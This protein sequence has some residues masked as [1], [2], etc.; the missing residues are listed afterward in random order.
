MLGKWKSS[1]SFVDRF[2]RSKET[3]LENRFTSLRRTVADAQDFYDL[4]PCGYHSVNQDGTVVA[5]NDTELRW[6]GYTRDEVVGRMRFADLITREGRATFEDKFREFKE[7]GGTTNLEFEIV[8]KDSTTFPV[9]LSAT[10]VRDDAGNY[11]SVHSILLDI[12]ER[13]RTEQA[14]RETNEHLRL[15]VHNA[16]DYALI[17]LDP[18]GLV[19]SWNPGA[20]RI[21][22]YCPEEIIGKHFSCFYPAEV[23][24]QG[25]P[26]VELE[27]AAAAGRFEDEGW[28]VRKDG[29]RFWANVIITALRDEAGRLRG[30]S[31]LT[32]D[33]T[34]RRRAEESIRQLNAE[35]EQ[36]VAARTAELA[37]ANRDLT[38]KNQ[39]N[40][41][42]VYSVSHDLRAPLVNLQGFSRELEVSCR[43][44]RRLLDADSVPAPVRKRGLALLDEDMAE[45]LRFIQTGVLRLGRIIDALLHLSRVGRVE[46]QWQEVDIADMTARVIASLR[47]TIDERGATVTA[48]PL[49]PARGDATALEQVFANLIG[50]ALKYLDPRRPG[51]IEV[52]AARPGP[53]GL[54]TYYVRDNG[55]GIPEAYHAKVFQAFQRAHPEVAAGEGMGLAIVRRIVERHNG[56]VWV[57]SRPGEGSTFYVALPT[58]RGDGPVANGASVAAS[59]VQRSLVS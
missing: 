8:R 19:V 25:W 22:G 2:C 47:G 42:F 52:G 54:Q 46:Y 48:G 33:L 30:F 15:L 5:I 39:E 45:S 24:E 35:L 28:R 43:E 38:Q 41:M 58:A 6:L 29:S 4:A 56:K 57:E 51:V 12:T 27:R 17:V 18:Q 31:K 23:A 1:P 9:M 37:D 14:L 50:N 40:E 34:E 21:K 26:Q 44:M 20:E 10:A 3:A 16:I 36:R 11:V 59:R 7:R 13:K 53:D 55:L 32:R 49:P